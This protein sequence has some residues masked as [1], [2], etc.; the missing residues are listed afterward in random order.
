[1]DDRTLILIVSAIVLSGTLVAF[2]VQYVRG[3]RRDD[4]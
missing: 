3:R 1:M 4:D 2:I